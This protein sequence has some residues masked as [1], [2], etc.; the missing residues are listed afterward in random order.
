MGSRHVDELH[1]L[2]NLPEEA[3]ELLGS[4]P[5]QP[6]IND[7]WLEKKASPD[8]QRV[9]MHG[10]FVTRYCNPVEIG[11]PFDSETGR[12]HF[13][14]GG[15]FD[16]KEVLQ[17]RFAGRVDDALIARLAF[18]LEMEGGVSWTSRTPCNPYEDDE[19]LYDLQVDGW[20]EPLATLKERLTQAMEVL[21][22]QGPA[23]AR[24][25]AEQL[26]YAGLIT[27]LESFLWET[28]SYWVNNEPDVLNEFIDKV[29]KFQNPQFS[30]SQVRKWEGEWFR[31][32]VNLYLQNLVWHNEKAVNQVF[33]EGLGVKLKSW[34]FLRKA[35]ETR[36]HIVH[37]SG[38]DKDGRPIQ[39][40]RD[41]IVQ[42]RSDI[43]AF[44]ES[45]HHQ[46]SARAMG[47]PLLE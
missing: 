29:G 33:A 8:D 41:E 24:A 35:L 26:V 15:P 4:H 5:D 27:D 34:Q 38:H 7:H 42:L 13:I 46:L 31:R 9:A 30:L 14:F 17:A 10:W 22:L 1:E 23:A 32:E 12:Y 6:D 2:S 3:L 45:I 16:A 36:H 21:N 47:F 19:P 39:I 40:M 28:A 44:A 11:T 37:R 25:R 43:D 20:A 18:D